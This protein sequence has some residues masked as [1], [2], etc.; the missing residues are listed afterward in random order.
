MNI[1]PPELLNDS[2]AT[3]ITKPQKFDRKEFYPSS[4]VP[5]EAQEFRLL[6]VYSTGNAGAY[7]RFPTETMRNGELGFAGFKYVSEY[8]GKQ[9]EGI[10]RKVNWASPGREKIDDEFVT[11]KQALVWTVWSYARERVELMIV[12]QRGLKE[13]IQEILNEAEDYT[14]DKK[15][16]IANFLLKLTRKGSGLETSYSILPKIKKTEA[17][18]TKAFAEVADTAQ[19]EKLLSGGH[20]MLETTGFSSN[21]E[22]DS[23][24]GGE[25]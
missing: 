1:L 4:L 13:S 23:N 5:D 15:T 20:P 24:D 19:V 14:F 6:G 2:A 17:A 9:P 25:F 18:V 7:W 3:A 11:P 21:N 12:E 16:G 10:A 22:S 8:P